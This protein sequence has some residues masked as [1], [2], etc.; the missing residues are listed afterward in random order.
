MTEFCKKNVC[1]KLETFNKFRPSFCL[2]MLNI[3]AFQKYS[4]SFRHD[5][6]SERDNAVKI[7]VFNL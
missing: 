7:C 1:I 6:A 2:T 5:V 3:V 4:C